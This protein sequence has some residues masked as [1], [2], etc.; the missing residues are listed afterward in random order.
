M[1]RFIHHPT[2]SW[3]K[4]QQ[5]TNYAKRVNCCPMEKVESNPK[6]QTCL[7]CNTLYITCLFFNLSFDFAH[8]CG[9]QENLSKTYSPHLCC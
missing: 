5:L 4:V 6:W 1:E 9:M 3:N 7:M 8:E 2:W